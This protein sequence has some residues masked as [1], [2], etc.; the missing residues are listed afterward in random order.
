M[1]HQT[2]QTTIHQTKNILK[3]INIITYMCVILDLYVLYFCGFDAK[4]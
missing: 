4:H 2:V 1:M 3:L